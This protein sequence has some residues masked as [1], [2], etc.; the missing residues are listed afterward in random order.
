MAENQIFSCRG[1]GRNT[2]RPGWILQWPLCEVCSAEWDRRIE[3]PEFV[4]RISADSMKVLF[5]FLREMRATVGL[6]VARDGT[7]INGHA[8]ALAQGLVE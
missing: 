7:I 1:C 2:D 5:A 4:H 3:D 8:I 6:E